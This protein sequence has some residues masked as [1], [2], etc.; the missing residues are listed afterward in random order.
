M[1]AEVYVNTPLLSLDKPFSYA[2]PK[3]LEGEAVKGVRV[4]VPF[5]YS[6]RAMEGIITNVFEKTDFENGTVKMKDEDIASLAKQAA[7]QAL[8]N[9]KKTIVTV[10]PIPNLL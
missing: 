4:K 3:K 6:D 5:G 10:V 7:Q 8:L 2:I 9:A 1:Y